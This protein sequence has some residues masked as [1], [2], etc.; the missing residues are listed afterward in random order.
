MPKLWSDPL[1]K[2]LVLGVLSI[3]HNAMESATGV[4]NA[5]GEPFNKF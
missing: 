2:I 4:N 3:D 1:K 5:S